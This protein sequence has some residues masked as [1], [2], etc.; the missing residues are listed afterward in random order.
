MYVRLTWLLDILIII[1]VCEAYM[2][3]RY[4]NNNLCV[5]LTWLL[6]ILI[7]CVCEAYVVARFCM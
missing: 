4:I 5:K 1:Y 7:I 2:V 3:A 6:D